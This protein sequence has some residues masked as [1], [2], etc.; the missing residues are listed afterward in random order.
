[1]A[2]SMSSMPPFSARIQILTITSVPELSILALAFL[3]SHRSVPSLAILHVNHRGRIQLIARDVHLDDMEL[4]PTP[5]T[6]LPPT[7]IHSRCLPLTD[8]S[9]ILIPITTS[10]EDRMVHDGILVI[11]GREIL[12]FNLASIDS[13]TK[14]TN[15]RRRLESRKNGG[16]PEE[17]RKARQK[18]AERESRVREPAAS[19]RWPW[20]EVTGSVWFQKNSI[21]RRSLTSSRSVVAKLMAMVQGSSLVIRLVDSRCYPLISQTSPRSY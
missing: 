16:N 2:I 4:S 13:Q 21:P 17:A 6:V 8:S 18:E 7:L 9:P 10:T 20:S 15:K 14:Q 1:M 12:F 19:V 3:S 11:G 5:S